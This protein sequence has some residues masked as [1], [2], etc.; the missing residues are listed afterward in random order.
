MYRSATAGLIA[1]VMTLVAAP[2]LS[3]QAQDGPNFIEVGQAAPDLALTGATRWG[4]IDQEVHL[5]DFQGEAVVLAFFPAARTRGCTIQMQAYRDQYADLFHGGRNVVLI[6]ISADSG[7]DLHSWAKDADFPF[8]FG[9]DPS[10]HVYRSL[11]GVP[12]DNGRTGRTVIVLDPDGTVAEV[13]PRFVEVDPTSY[14]QLAAIVDRVAPAV[15]DDHEME[16]GAD[17]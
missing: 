4:V 10:G 16:A 7:E 8:L 9:S 6:A 17:D 5:S 14:E 11:G 15:E 12:R 2:G 13:I 1:G 3:A